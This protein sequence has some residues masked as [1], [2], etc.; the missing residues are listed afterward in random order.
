MNRVKKIV[1]IF[2]GVP[3]TIIAFIF[4][5]KILFDSL[6]KI[7]DHL[8]DADPLLLLIGV[9]FMLGF[10]LIRAVAWT[11][12][13]EFYTEKE[14]SI[15]ESI[16]LYSLAET[17]RYV[18]GNIFSFVSR[19]QKFS[20]EKFPKTIVIKALGLEAIIMVISA[21]IIS[22]PAILSIFNFEKFKLLLFL[23][24]ILIPVFIFLIYKNVFKVKSAAISIFPNKSIFEY[25]NL[26]SISALAW[27]FFGVANY[28]FMVAIFP[29]DP[30]TI[31][32]I[33]SIFVLSWLVGYL[34]FIAPMGLGVREAILIYLL[35][36]FT[37]LYANA[38][39]AIFTR[40]LFVISEVIFLGAS[41]VFHKKIKTSRKSKNLI[42]IIIVAFSSF[43]YIT[44]TIFFSI[45]K[46]VNFY[47]GKF[48]LGN[49]E[50][51]VW[52]TVHERFF[53]FSNPDS[54]GELSR[55][56]AHADFI[57]VL[58]AP[59]YAI[60]PSVNVLLIA[61]SLIIGLGGFFIYLIAR[62]IIL[63]EKIAVLLSAGYFLNCF[64]LEQNLF[65]FH[66]VSLATTFL[67]GAFYFLIIEKY[68]LMTFM[69]LLAVLCK[70][71]VYL[72]AGIFGGFLYLKGKNK[73][74]SL[75]LIGSFLMFYLLMSF[76]IPMARSGDHLALEYLT[77]LG[78]SPI[79]IIFSPILKPILFFS[80]VFR[81]ETLEYLKLN[82][83]HTGFL[84]LLSPLYL[85]FALPDFFINILS[86]NPNLRSDQ[87]HYG[88]L[89]TPFIYISTIFGIKKLLKFNLKQISRNTIFYY[90]L[91]F[92]LFS[93]YLYS[94]LPGAK[95]GDVAAFKPDPNRMMVLNEIAKIPSEKSVSAT[96]NIAA[97]MVKREKIYVIPNVV[98]NVDYLVFYKN[99][100]DLAQEIL[101]INNNY[102]EIFNSNNL[103]ILKRFTARDKAYKL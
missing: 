90:L 4:V 1:K 73:F 2:L 57:L 14:K 63:S 8:K 6:P 102:I 54:M 99:N 82:L 52:N 69:L 72:V 48:D 41:F 47:T 78:N 20:T 33:G 77:Y 24:L 64:I 32:K 79:E 65:D 100:L 58:F 70:E 97:H 101:M 29:N 36:A 34:S 95:K 71:N 86:D 56:S 87:Y 16:Y 91:F 40:I 30:N 93:A 28:F 80:Q 50:N 98:D 21:G 76:F 85:I 18:P 23:P 5:G 75:L 38:T 89:I 7:V 59:F 103:I 11:K 46:H 26:I 53:V 67:L 25:I 27:I 84:S 81:I 39:I 19:V 96:N 42:P 61:Q 3:L 88:A 31:F 83:I 35:S 74:G 51:T 13:I 55:L 44:Y 10:F 94:P 68:R 62:K 49:M 17:K 92:I 45:S 37:P 15:H 60:Y 43:I 9:I 12:I 66:A 22:T